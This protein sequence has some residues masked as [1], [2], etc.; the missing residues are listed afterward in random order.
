MTRILLRFFNFPG[1]LL[2]TLFGIAI[3]TSL[4][5][6]WPLNYLQPDIVL[7]VVIWAALKR[8]FWEGGWVTLFIADFA[9]LHSATPQGMFLISY[10][11]VFLAVRGLSR[12]VVIP[13]LS[14]LVMVTLFVSVFWKLSCLGVLYLLG[15]SANQGRHTLLFLFPGAIIEGAMALWVYGWLEK[16]DWATFKSARTEHSEQDEELQIFEGA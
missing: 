14:S 16:Y 2:L 15:A 1:L 12:L 10:M 3:Q 11:A 4:F 9:E 6:F 5:T 13:N 7:L 8:G